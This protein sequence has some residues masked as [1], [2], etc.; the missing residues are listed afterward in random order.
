MMYKRHV[1]ITR[2]AS[3]FFIDKNLV[4][5]YRISAVGMGAQKEWHMAV[6]DRNKEEGLGS[7]EQ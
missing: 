1:Y 4:K 7:R 6:L 3:Y 2:I 5:Y